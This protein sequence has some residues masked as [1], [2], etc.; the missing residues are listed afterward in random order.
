MHEGVERPDQLAVG[1]DQV[2][3][4]GTDDG[5]PHR[6][7]VGV[8]IVIAEIRNAAGHSKTILVAPP[9]PAG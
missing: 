1:V 6:P 9:G 2:A 3:A 4:P 5:V 7:A 8:E